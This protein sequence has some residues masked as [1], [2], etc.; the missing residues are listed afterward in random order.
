MSCVSLQFKSLC[1][2][3]QRN[4]FLDSSR[5]LGA[6]SHRL[7]LLGF[8]IRLT[9]S[10]IFLYLATICLTNC[11]TY[12]HSH[13]VSHNVICWQ[14]SSVCLK[15]ILLRSLLICYRLEVKACNFTLKLFKLTL[16]LD[17]SSKTKGLRPNACR[18]FKM[19][20]KLVLRPELVLR[21]SS[22]PKVKVTH[23]VSKKFPPLKSL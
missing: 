17:R 7:S 5:R 18:H 12:A 1:C 13:C 11:A 2:I 6:A 23:C 15:W 8:R 4:S 10:W 9:Y 3:F 19:L 14:T 20:C 16:V 22:Y 21:S